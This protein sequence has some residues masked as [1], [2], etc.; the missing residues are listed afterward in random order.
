MKFL[1]K[2]S[3]SPVIAILFIII[4]VI[5]G[6]GLIAGVLHS[7]IF[8]YSFTSEAQ[9]A[10]N[11]PKISLS[12]D[13]RIMVELDNGLYYNTIDVVLQFSGPHSE[14]YVFDFDI[15]VDGTKLDEI[16]E[17][18][19]LSTDSSVTFTKGRFTGY[20][21]EQGS[22]RYTIGL[23]DS[24]NQFAHLKTQNDY[25]VEVT[26]GHEKGISSH[27]YRAD[28][29]R[30]A[31]VLNY[32]ITV[33]RKNVAE[34]FNNWPGNNK[35]NE[36]LNDLIDI[37]KSQSDVNFMIDEYFSDDEFVDWTAVASVTDLM[38]Y[39]TVAFNDDDAPIIAEFYDTRVDILFY[40]AHRRYCNTP[41]L[42]GDDIEINKV[43]NAGFYETGI[44]V[45]TSSGG[46][47]A[48]Y[49]C[50]LTPDNVFDETVNSFHPEI[51]A[52]AISVIHDSSTLG[53]KYQQPTCNYAGQSSYRYWDHI[54]I[55]DGSY[56]TADDLNLAAWHTNLVGPYY[57][58]QYSPQYGPYFN[59]QGADTSYPLA[60]YNISIFF[61]TVIHPAYVQTY[62]GVPDYVFTITP[63]G[64][65]FPN[66]EH[67]TI[68]YIEA[69]YHFPNIND[70]PLISFGQKAIEYLTSQIISGTPSIVLYKLSLNSVSLD[71]N[72]DE[73]Y[74]AEAIVNPAKY[75]SK[76]LD[77]II[78]KL[79]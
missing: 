52:D 59:T 16:E 70:S 78:N 53:Y 11:D 44:S 2:R 50:T 40:D 61:G 69:S 17:W 33:I 72:V 67:G 15:I 54:V 24:D 58:Q 56:L 36:D 51:D 3:T 42:C 74:E 27:T 60:Q 65:R 47:V 39:D 68:M 71:Q 18:L 13:N 21:Q 75:E 79:V 6:G 23:L 63:A 20:F 26:V 10:E 64:I 32:S 41:W 28:F 14:L 1:S 57:I 48:R 35:R 77:K 8:D 9:L 55:S 37:L 19:I 46:Y 5:A 30:E 76:Y 43:I 25:S 31:P 29:P 34:L 66:A 4:L 62:D 12:V 22:E 49:T 38:I 7:G 45:R 73:G